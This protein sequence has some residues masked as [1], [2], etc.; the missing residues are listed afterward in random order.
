MTKQVART[1]SIFEILSMFTTEDQAV[2]WFESVQWNG[3]PQ[4]SHCEGTKKITIA[5]SKRYTYWCGPCRKHFTVRTGTVMESSKLPVR[6]WAITMYAVMTARKGISS[7]QLSKELG[8]TQKSAWFLLH[9]V[10]EACKQTGV[11]LS[12]VVEVDETYIG[13]KAKNRHA[14][15][16]LE[17]QGTGM[18]G[19]QAVLGIRE[20]HGRTKLFPIA[21]TTQP[22]LQGAIQA[23]VEPN[24]LVYTDDHG[25]YRGL[26]YPHETVRH[27]AKEYVNGMAHTNGIESVWALLKRGYY[28]TYHNFSAK[29]VR[30]YV[31]EVAFRL[32]DGNC[33]VDT[34]DRM[35][36]LAVGMNGKRIPYRELIA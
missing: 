36:S 25:G 19:K 2:M 22:V 8:I 31:D 3:T 4:C 28:G 21:E 15:K 10:R 7:L 27:S 35:R 26:A 30:R 11:K 17:R 18:V 29:H 32:N 1:K 9:R 13:G 24:T 16:K 23:H 5:K 33:Q 20:R 12:K 14:S 34:V 6:L